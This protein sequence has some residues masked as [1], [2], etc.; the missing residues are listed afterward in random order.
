MCVLWSHVYTCV[1]SEVG[2][3]FLPRS[4][5][6]FYTLEAVPHLTPELA[7]FHSLPGQLAPGIP[8]LCHTHLAFMWVLGT[9]TPVLTLY[10]LSPLL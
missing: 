5:T 8:H 9:A 10:P 2:V 3:S 4:R 6:P 1:K 7:E